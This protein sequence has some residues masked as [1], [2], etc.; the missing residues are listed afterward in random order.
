MNDK[1]LNFINENR[2]RKDIIN[3][4]DINC[5][6]LETLQGSVSRFIALNL[7]L[8]TSNLHLIASPRKMYLE[9]TAGLL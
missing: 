2:S 6:G 8:T 3:E 4:D 9:H 1:M 7:Q 5:Q